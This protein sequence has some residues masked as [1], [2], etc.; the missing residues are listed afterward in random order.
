M[1]TPAAVKFVASLAA[2]GSD[3][4]AEANQAL[5]LKPALQR[6]IGDVARAFVSTTDDPYSKEANE[7][8]L[9]L[10]WFRLGEPDT[11]DG[12]AA[13]GVAAAA[14]VAQMPFQEQIDVVNDVVKEIAI[15]KKAGNGSLGST[16]DGN[17]GTF[18]S[19]R[20]IVDVLR[21]F[22]VAFN[23]QHGQL[24][25]SAPSALAVPTIEHQVQSF[26]HSLATFAPPRPI[27]APSLTG[28]DAPI[29]P[30][31]LAMPHAHHSG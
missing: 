15:A 24:T 2:G 31:F 16:F 11:S 29:S 22:T 9:K 6:E 7:Y 26:L 19:A 3:P 30:I 14:Q 8:V 23:A 18:E 25:N 21:D 17:I 1:S 27:E 4:F 10:G 20:N 13:A 12:R 5:S 28:R